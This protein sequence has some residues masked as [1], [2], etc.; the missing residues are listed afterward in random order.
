MAS[1]ESLEM[2]NSTT[3]SDSPSEMTAPNLNVINSPPKTTRNNLADIIDWLGEGDYVVVHD[4]Y[5][6]ARYF[7]SKCDE[8][9]GA[10]D[11]LLDNCRVIY[12]DVAS[13]PGLLDDGEWDWYI[14]N[15]GHKE[16][17]CQ[18]QQR[19]SNPNNLPHSYRLQLGL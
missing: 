18:L 3:Q 12:V 5:R 8:T 7:H 4:G 10:V 17:K 16:C 19:C 6:Y 14:K 13:L 9:N 1:V 11:Q 15:A 2:I